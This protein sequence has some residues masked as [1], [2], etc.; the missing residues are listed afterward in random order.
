MNSLETKKQH[1][2]GFLNSEIGI[3]E[4]EAHIYFEEYLQA[5]NVI[6]SIS[7]TQDVWKDKGHHCPSK[8][9]LQSVT[10]QAREFLRKVSE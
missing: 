9:E 10:D 3:T 7:E 1:I 2:R 6:K 5:L 4:E 8:S